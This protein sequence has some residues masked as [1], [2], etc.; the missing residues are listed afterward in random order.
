LLDALDLNRHLE[1]EF[2]IKAFNITEAQEHNL[3]NVANLLNLINTKLVLNYYKD[4]LPSG[5]AA[6]KTLLE[7]AMQKDESEYE[8]TYQQL[9]PTASPV[10]Q[11]IIALAQC[12]YTIDKMKRHNDHERNNHF[13]QEESVQNKVET[14]AELPSTLLPISCEEE[15]SLEQR[16]NTASNKVAFLSQNRNGLSFIFEDAF[17]RVASGEPGEVKAQFKD[18]VNMI[19]D[20]VLQTKDSSAWASFCDFLQQVYKGVA[21]EK[22]NEVQTLKSVQTSSLDLRDFSILTGIQRKA[23]PKTVSRSGL[24][25]ALSIAE[26]AM[27]DFEQ[28]RNPH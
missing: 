20:I 6:L 1:S 15:M 19:I 8:E 3:R 12:Y 2:T 17:S 16:V 24:A 21:N 23:F 5:E 28:L 13:A 18:H 11:Q 27:S 4:H 10:Q 22:G 14:D 26:R 25:E 9:Y 7:Q